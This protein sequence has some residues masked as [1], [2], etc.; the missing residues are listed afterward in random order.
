M[1]LS[2]KLFK[3]IKKLVAYLPFQFLVWFVQYS[4]AGFNWYTN[5]D[6]TISHI[7]KHTLFELIPCSVISI[8][9]I[10]V[11]NMI[12][13]WNVKPFGLAL[14][15][16]ISSL[17]F[18]FIWFPIVFAPLYS[19]VWGFENIH[20]V[21]IEYILKN[22]NNHIFIFLSLNATP[23]IQYFFFKHEEKKKNIYEL[24]LNEKNK[25]RT[26][27]KFN[28]KIYIS[29]KYSPN[30]IIISSIIVI[31]A[32]GSYSYAFTSNNRKVILTKTLK[33]W[34]NLLPQ[35]NFF[36]IHRSTIINIKQVDKIEEQENNTYKVFLYDIQ[37]PFEMS[38]RYGSLFKKRFEF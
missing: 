16:I 18:A 24:Y 5:H 9:I 11:F 6:V 28:D 38:R 14:I 37:Q 36:R 25:L 4:W 34:E 8:L 7:I 29:N 15:Y 20:R 17:F 19:A 13:K 2:V 35:E 30:F 3:T 1:K 12:I 26:T 33:K 21:T 23:Y 31:C 10:L 32:D 27:L 22:F